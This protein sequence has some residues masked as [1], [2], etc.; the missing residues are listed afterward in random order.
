MLVLLTI[1]VVIFVKFLKYT[2][3]INTKSDWYYKMIPNYC[4]CARPALNDTLQTGTISHLNGTKNVRDGKSLNKYWPA[5]DHTYFKPNN[6]TKV[7]HYNQ[8]SAPLYIY[9]W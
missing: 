1:Y 7:R 3:Y 9:L 4:S 2:D 5:T 8:H 6:S